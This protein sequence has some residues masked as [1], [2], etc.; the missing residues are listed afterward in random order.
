MLTYFPTRDCC[1]VR[2]AWPFAPGFCSFAP[3]SRCVEV[4]QSQRRVGWIEDRGRRGADD[5]HPP[6]HTHTSG[7]L[8]RSVS[9]VRTGL[10]V[11]HAIARLR[12][13]QPR[14]LHPPV[15]PEAAARLKVTET[16]LYQA[17]AK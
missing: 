14:R 11:V 8:P 10:I 13:G 17:L 9:I 16:T 7:Q 15:C 3:A 12:G 4:L 6:F 5:L 2:F 1:I